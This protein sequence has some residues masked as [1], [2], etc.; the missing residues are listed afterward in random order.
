MA[1]H[2]D[3]SRNAGQAV[4]YEAVATIM[5]IESLGG[6]RV[7]GIN[8]LGRFLGQPD[9]NTRYVALNSLTKVRGAGAMCLDCCV[10]VP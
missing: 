2:A 4:L 8:I 1:T 10:V 7:L 5:G 6:L 9:N 3:A